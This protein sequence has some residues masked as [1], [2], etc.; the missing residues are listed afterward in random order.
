VTI[1]YDK[2]ISSRVAFNE[3]CRFDEPV[4]IF[5]FKLFNQKVSNI[6]RIAIQFQD[7]KNL[8]ILICLSNSSLVLQIM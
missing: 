3:Y 8:I 4:V 6:V 5:E 2:P 7:I 1:K